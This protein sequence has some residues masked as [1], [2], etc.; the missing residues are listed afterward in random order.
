MRCNSNIKLVF[1]AIM[2]I[3]SHYII[4][5][6][7]NNFNKESLPFNKRMVKP[8]N[9]FRW[10]AFWGILKGLQLLTIPALPDIT[11]SP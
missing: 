7:L 10:K 9:S 8:Q 5:F 6:S 4:I 1:S 11:P 3:F 2:F